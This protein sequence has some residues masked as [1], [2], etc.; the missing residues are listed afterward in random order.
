MV[1]GH[2]YRAYIS[3]NSAQEMVCF[4]ICGE[5]C[6]TQYG[7]VK[8]IDYNADIQYSYYHIMTT[9]IVTINMNGTDNRRDKH[10]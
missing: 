9:Y 8:V 5:S 6:T 7:K 2:R 3:L 4:I 10:S 1:D